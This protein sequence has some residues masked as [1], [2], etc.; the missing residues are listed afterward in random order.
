MKEKRYFSYKKRGYT[1]YNCLRKR[2]IPII[3][4]GVSGNN[5]NQGKK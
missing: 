1:T 3:S 5:D 4:E 2:K